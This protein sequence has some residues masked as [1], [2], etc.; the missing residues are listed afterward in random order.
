[1]FSMN[2]LEEMFE[3]LGYIDDRLLFTH[4]RIHE[5]SLDEGFV[6][7]MYDKDVIRFLE[8]VPRFRELEVTDIHLKTKTKP[9]LTNRAREWKEREKS[10][11]KSKSKPKTA[12]KPFPAK[13]HCSS[14]PFTISP[15]PRQ[16]PSQPYLSQPDKRRLT[17]WQSQ[18]DP[19]ADG[20]RTKILGLGLEGLE[21]KLEWMAWIKD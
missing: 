4:F 9:K 6:L 19:L 2:I 3:D 5:E 16:N 18:E 8:Y 11:S 7:L 1:M 10:K 21:R 13:H 12:S 15:A 14:I 17:P 20:T